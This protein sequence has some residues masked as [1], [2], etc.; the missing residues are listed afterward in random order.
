[1]SVRAVP[2]RLRWVGPL[3]LTALSVGACAEE[4]PLGPRT[5]DVRVD[6]HDA[7]PAQ[8]PDTAPETNWGSSDAGADTASTDTGPADAVLIDAGACSIE[9][10]APAL[11]GAA[12]TAACEQ[13]P[14]TT[15]P[16]ASGTHYGSWPFF[17]AYDQPVP[18]GY[19]LHAMEHG[20]V[21]IAYNCPD[22]CPAEVAAAKAVM[23]AVPRKTTC[24]KP[25]PPVIVTPDP[26]LSVRFAAA[27]WG[28]ILRAP[29]F[30]SATFLR[31]ATENANHGPEF[32]PTDC[33][34][35]LEA[36]GWCPQP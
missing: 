22:G 11:E 1:M 5:V 25:R 32:F 36:G 28:H 27:S 17:R 29:C 19:L 30:D 31:F 12:H 26:T 2:V 13:V 15:N 16:P 21:I 7:Q 33:G 8:Q 3:L 23:E 34:N 24:P 4:T 9:E 18:W 35:E 10:L 14:H 6:L 20:A